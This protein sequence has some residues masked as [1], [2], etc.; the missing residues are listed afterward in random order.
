MTT[1]EQERRDRITA[2]I[3]GYEQKHAR[4]ALPAACDVCE[5]SM[6]EIANSSWRCPSCGSVLKVKRKNDDETT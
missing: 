2:A 3:L 1:N 5:A 6:M 4:G